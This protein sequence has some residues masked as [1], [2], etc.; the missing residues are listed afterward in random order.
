MTSSPLSRRTVL[1][2]GALAGAAASLPSVVRPAPAAAAAPVWRDVPVSPGDGVTTLGT[3]ALLGPHEGWVGGGKRT[4]GPLGLLHWDGRNWSR[5][6]FPDDFAGGRLLVAAS[7]RRKVWAMTNALNASVFWDGSA[8]RHADV[9]RELPSASTQLSSFPVQLSPQSLSA[10]RDGTAWS[11]IAD[12]LNSKYVVMRWEKGAWV[13]ADVPVPQ[14]AMVELVSVRSH[15]DVWVAG[16]A[17]DAA[18]RKAPFTVHWNGRAWTDV[19]V[20]PVPGSSKS[21]LIRRIRPVSARLAWAFRS[22]DSTGQD[23][24][25]L[26]WTGGAAWEEFR[27]PQEFNTPSGPL[28]DDGRSGVWIGGSTYGSTQYLH[29]EGGA[30]TTV[31][32]PARTADQIEVIDMARVPGTRTI[33]ATGRTTQLNTP[34]PPG[35]LDAPLLERFH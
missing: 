10:G 22:N 28:A 23:Q 19:T 35:Y 33:L 12:V 20:L 18:L 25:L 1:S 16:G 2:A 13:L 30:W 7:S 31:Q 6:P 29:F 27:L 14:G 24:T 32:G 21:Q 15:R 17:L 4:W 3:L 5:F 11:V 8:W 26:R 34:E 9:R